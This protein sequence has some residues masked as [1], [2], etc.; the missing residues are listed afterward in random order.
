M[1]RRQDVIRFHLRDVLALTFTR[2]SKSRRFF[3][4]LFSNFPSSRLAKY[5]EK[6]KKQ[7]DSVIGLSN[8]S[9]NHVGIS[10]FF[11]RLPPYRAQ[12]DRFQGE[13]SCVLKQFD[14]VARKL[15]LISKIKIEMYIEHKR[16]FFSCSLGLFSDNMRYT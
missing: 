3:S 2:L 6:K 1:M 16:T 12:A 8:L 5:A 13:V 10:V 9:E 7:F 14:S 4:R 15:F 11:L